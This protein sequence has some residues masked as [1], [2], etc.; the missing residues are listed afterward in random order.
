MK[1]IS[2]LSIGNSFSQDAQRYLHDLAKKEGVSLEA[3]NLYI[4]GC[5]LEHH[6]RNMLGDKKEYHLE[7][8][9]HD[10]NGFRTSIKEALLA[11]SWDYVTVQQASHHSYQE[12]TYQPYMGELVN[13]I[14]RMCPQTKVLVHQTWGYESG[15]QR[16]MDQGFE[17]YEEMFAEVKGCYQ[18][19]ARE[20]QA[21]GILPCGEAFAYALQHGI[22]KV[23]RDTFHASMGVGRL[24]LAMV[25]YGY[26][27]GNPVD[28]IDFRDLDREV[29]EEEYAIAKEA[30]KFALAQ[31]N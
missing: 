2:V 30:V 25:W 26:L 12:W 1:T 31:N 11:R 19:A 23:H 14:R 28:S 22:G 13:Y 18:K 17:T 3:V 20:V 29:R 10:A 5:S 21:D 16:L 6:F 7:I 4:G 24:I 8:N 15:S 9:G 27:T